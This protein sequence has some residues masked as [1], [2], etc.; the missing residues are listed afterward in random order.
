MVQQRRN[1]PLT[2][3]RR[4]LLSAIL[5]LSS[6]K[7]KNHTVV[8]VAA[9]QQHYSVADSYPIEFGTNYDPT[10]I[11][12][13]AAALHHRGA[14]YGGYG[15]ASREALARLPLVLPETSLSLEEDEDDDDDDEMSSESQSHSYFRVRDQGGQLFA[16]RLYHEDALESSSLYD[17]MFDAPVLVSRGVATTTVTTT[18]TTTGNIENNNDDPQK[19]PDGGMIAPTTTTTTTTTTPKMVD[20]ATTTTTPAQIGGATATTAEKKKK[21]KA[22]PG[23]SLQPTTRVIRSSSTNNK[24]GESGGGASSSPGSTTTTATSSTGTTTTTTATGGGA[25][26]SSSLSASSDAEVSSSSSSRALVQMVESTSVD[27]V[28]DDDDNMMIDPI[29]IEMSLLDHLRGVCGQVH[30]GYWSYEW[31]FMGEITQFHV[32]YDTKTNQ[33]KVDRVT[34]LGTYARRDLHVMDLE[35]DPNDDFFVNEWAQDEPEVARVVDY[36]LDGTLCDATEPATPRRTHAILQCCG[37]K[38]VKRHKGMVHRDGRPFLTDL[39]A[40]LDVVEDPDLKCTY[41]FTICTPLLCGD[42]TTDHNNAALADDD[43]AAVVAAVAEKAAIDAARLVEDLNGSNKINDEETIRQILDRT[44][45]KLCL[46]SSQSGGGWWTYE[47]CHEKTIRQFHETLGVRKNSAGA[48]VASKV[49]ES[50]HVLGKYDPVSEAHVQ[51]EDEYKYVVNATS[52]TS[53]TST[54]S[55]TT[56]TAVGTSWGEG[57]GAYYQVEYTGGDTCDTS[58]VTD[59]AIV[60]GTAGKTTMLRRAA[61]VRYHCGSAFDVQVG[62]DSTCHYIVDV[63]V[64]GLC[65]HPLFRAPISKRQIMKCLPVNNEEEDDF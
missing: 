20:G 62:E 28:D 22:L 2:W 56:N 57:N 13:H 25:S 55:T 46:Q 7:E 3:V 14:V 17:S 29:V 47:F 60:A 4:M 48:K 19:N 41:N 10:V 58:D 52:T 15:R 64:P 16:C 65:R 49:V 1:N 38:V 63:K 44:L 32:E 50:E 45:T 31:C 30:K 23:S 11:D 5:V 43:D 54:T 53:S 12:P 34:N 27:D 9:Q 37:P 26:S 18:T 61:S 42:A 33:V 35:N 21:K 51:D 36:H 8:V 24:N 59:S 6:T 39:V 40:V